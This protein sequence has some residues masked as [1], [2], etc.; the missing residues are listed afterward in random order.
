MI[1]AM[2]LAHLVGDYILQWDALARRKSIDIR[3]VILHGAIVLV[4]TWLFAMAIDPS[5]WAG[6]LFISLTHFVIDAVQVYYK[7]P[8]PP[9]ARFTVDQLLHFTMIFLALAAGGYLTL[10]TLG[11]DLAA[12]ATAMPWL[13]AVTFYAFITMPAWV[14]LKFAVYAAVKRAPPDFPAQP[15]KYVGITERVLIATFVASGQVLLV[16]LAT[17]PRLVT[18]WPQAKQN[19]LDRVYV[20]E[21]LASACLA[22]ATG[23]ALRLVLT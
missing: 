6:V 8:I 22:V 18:A 4:V 11:Q 16:P 23:I 19:Q 1:M 2:I 14:L 7:P 21:F 5:W 12:N 9:L 13:T 10:Q 15:S 20:A 3:G 17:L